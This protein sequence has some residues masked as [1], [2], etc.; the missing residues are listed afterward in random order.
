MK[1]D[2]KN[3]ADFYHDETSIFRARLKY[4]HENSRPD[5]LTEIKIWDAVQ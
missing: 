4:M 5:V 1:W 3:H 2:T